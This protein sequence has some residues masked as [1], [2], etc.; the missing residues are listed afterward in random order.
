IR[1]SLRGTPR[2]A[3]RRS[4]RAAI[5]GKKL[6]RIAAVLYG[7]ATLARAEGAKHAADFCRYRP[8]APD[9]DGAPEGAEVGCE[10]PAH[11][12]CAH[13]GRSASLHQSAVADLCQRAELDSAAAAR[14]AP[15]VQ[16]EESVLRA[17][18]RAIL[19]R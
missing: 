9:R 1:P 15:S 17:R 2:R 8:T 4:A 3:P 10:A 16:Q 5:I 18:P 13:G 6:D 7:R 19:D 14:T 12:T 11:R